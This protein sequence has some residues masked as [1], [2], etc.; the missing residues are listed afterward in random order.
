WISTLEGI[1]HFDEQKKVFDNYNHS[2]GY[3]LQEAVL[4]SCTKT[5][6]NNFFVGGVNAFVSFSP[7][8][9]KKNPFVPNVVISKFKVWT[10]NVSEDATTSESVYPEK[11]I[12]LK[13][14]QAAFTIYFA[15]LNFVFPNKNQYSYMLEGFDRNWNNVINERSATYTNIPP[16]DYVFRVRACNN[17]GV[18]NETGA[19]FEIE[20][21]PPPWKTWWAYLIYTL[22]FISILGGFIYYIL[23]K[24]QLETGITI[25][26]ME[27][28]NLE[29]NH[30]LRVRLFTN[31]SHELRTPLTLIIG[32]LN[33]ILAKNDMSEWLKLKLVLIFKNA[34]RLLWLVNQLMDF[35]KLESGFMKPNMVQVDFNIFLE[36]IMTSFRELATTK[37]ITLEL[38]NENTSIDTW[39]DPILMEKVFFNLLSNAFKH[40]SSNRKVIVSAKLID[41]NE[42][43]NYA[44][45]DFPANSALLL[46]VTD[47]GDGIDAAEI[48][49]IFEPF[50]QAH[51][52]EG[53]NIYG[54]GIGLNLC[55]GIVEL[56]YGTIWAESIV[57]IGSTFH[58]LLPVGNAHLS[59]AELSNS[60]VMEH[61][62]SVMVDMP[63]HIPA[64]VESTH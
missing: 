6:D 44:G 36:D 5:Q 37:Q 50:Y 2:N 20:I 12:K 59:Q 18:W 27:Q 52:H 29:E 31:F 41:K 13:Y 22:I 25:K 14:N 28:R 43:T 19:S 3:P 63:L 40:T 32:P 45:T 26:Q 58:L 54:T 15:A 56:H 35:R 39:F 34:Q 7:S 46:S 64:P 8:E 4:H 55:K 61:D 24:Q 21:L 60:K 49:K 23:K 1:S 16:G 62:R 10:D 11:R 57:N 42:A 30:Q 47:D 33:E 17:D 9:I 51:N 48:E 53:T 38:K